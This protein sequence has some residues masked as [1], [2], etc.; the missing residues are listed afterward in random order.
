[1]KREQAAFAGEVS[2]HYYFADFHGVDTGLVPALMILQLV[3]EAGVPLA[4]LLA[5][6]REHYFL[7]G[8]INSTVDDVPMKLQ[9]L[10]ET[11]ADGQIAH[12]DGVSIDYEDWHFNVRPSNTE[13]LLRLNLEALTQ[14]D[15]EHRRDEVLSLIRSGSS[16]TN[17]AR[18]TSF[19]DLSKVAGPTLEREPFSFAAACR[20]AFS[21]TDAQGIVYYGRYAPYFDVARV[22][23]FRNLGLAA[24]EHNDR[25]GEL[26]M[27]HFA[28]ALSGS[29]NV[30]RL[31]GSLLPCLEDR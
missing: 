23:Y 3:S 19:R 26:V 5:D 18:M 14:A 6:M 22:E 7:S 12:L 31:A 17:R 2:G 20:V 30:R 16:C 4:D 15:M 9:Q 21:D 28:I 1:M 24:H 10:K 25:D 11:Y 8:E 13:P 29:G 27:R